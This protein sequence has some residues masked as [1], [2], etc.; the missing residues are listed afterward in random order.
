MSKAAGI[1]SELRQSNLKTRL[2][3]AGFSKPNAT[4]NF[5]AIKLCFLIRYG[6]LFEAVYGFASAGFSKDSLMSLVMGG[7]AGFYIPEVALTLMKSSRQQRSFCSFPMHLTCLWSVLKREARRLPGYVE[8]LK[9]WPQVLRKSVPSFL[10]QYA[11]A[12]G[13]ATSRSSA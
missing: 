3:N 2:A 9:N 1:Q 13:Q 10:R 11:V 4:R 7:G 12:D 5:L 6:L 8:S